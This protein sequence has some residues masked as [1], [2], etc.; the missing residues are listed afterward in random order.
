MRRNRL[1]DVLSGDRGTSPTIG[2]VLLVGITVLLA[3]AAG[4]QLFGLAGSQQGTFASATVDYSP[5]EDR[6]AVTWLATAGAERLKVEILV[7]D[8]RRVVGLDGVGDRVVVDG[9]GVT[10]SSGSVGQWKSPTISDG[11]RVTVTVLA[12]KNGESVVVADR[13]ATV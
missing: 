3:T 7:G 1:A 4:S 11:D 2:A 10:V 5:G 9:D 6:V 12:V 13:S 8:E